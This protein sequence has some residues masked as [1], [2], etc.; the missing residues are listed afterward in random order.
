MCCKLRPH[1]CDIR[2][3]VQILYI[4]FLWNQAQKLILDRHMVVDYLTP[5]LNDEIAKGEKERQFLSF[6]S[7]RASSSQQQN[8]HQQQQHQQQQHHQ[9]Q[10][11][12]QQQQQPH[13]HHQQQQQ[14]HHQQQQ[15]HS[16]RRESEERRV[17]KRRWEERDDEDRYQYRGEERPRPLRDAIAPAVAAPL[18]V[19]NVPV[20]APAV[21]PA[22]ADQPLTLQQRID[23]LIN[24]TESQRRDN[25]G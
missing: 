6:F 19:I 5:Q 14:Q 12:H 21:R 18:P 23:K 1:R 3:W 10:H 7:G 4:V 20:E 8:Q 2:R 22:A 9:Q 11:H 15:R 25:I 13:H 24:L 16:P 17:R